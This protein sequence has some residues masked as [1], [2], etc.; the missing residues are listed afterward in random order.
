[1]I[2]CAPIADQS[3]QKANMN[4]LF[5]L[6]FPALSVGLLHVVLLFVG[7]QAWGEPILIKNGNFEKRKDS[8]LPQDW[9]LFSDNKNLS[10]GGMGKDDASKGNSCVV[11]SNSKK[12][13]SFQGLFQ[14]LKVKSGEQIEFNIYVKNNPE[15]PLV[16]G[17]HGQLSI[18]WYDAQGKEISRSWSQSWGSNLSKDKWVEYSLTDLAPSKA[19]KA[20]LAITLFPEGETTGGFL[21]DDAAAK[22]IK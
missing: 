6:K 1:M 8:S 10:F 2:L 14:T 4:L 9:M 5:G 16:G 3:P 13:T 7:I 19:V 11:F 21:A 12:K 22:K 15:N 20:N 17:S 18:E